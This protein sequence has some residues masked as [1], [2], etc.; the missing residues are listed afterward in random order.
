MPL[1]PLV[2]RCAALLLA[3]MAGCAA[4]PA[5]PPAPLPGVPPPAPQPPVPAGPS[6]ADEQRRL[7]R[8]LDGTPVSVGMTPDGRLRLE[9]PLQ[10][11]FDEGRA[12]VK[13]ALAKVLDL[14]AGGLRQ[15]KTTELRIA[16]PSD[17]NGSSLLAADRAASTRDYLIARG[18]S[19]LRFASVARGDGSG[20]EIVVSE[21]FAPAA[22]AR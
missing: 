3:A 16:A 15:Q 4:P 10:Y 20:V 5:V 21:R 2:L 9:V 22:P 18:V 7:G 13:P 8:L 6:L 19:A 11:S 12:A 17:A 1:R 14:M